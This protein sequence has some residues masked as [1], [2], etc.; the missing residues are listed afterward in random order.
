MND[1]PIIE[2][3]DNQSYE[4]FKEKDMKKKNGK[5]K[6]LGYEYHCYSCDNDGYLYNQ[7]QLMCPKCGHPF[8]FEILAERTP[9]W[10]YKVPLLHIPLPH[11]QP[12]VKADLNRNKEI[13][14]EVNKAFKQAFKFEEDYIR[15]AEE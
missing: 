13:H 8:G 3:L 12:Q 1:E 2:E 14:K 15:D 4:E 11:K 10:E 5:G 7:Y 9:K 6:F